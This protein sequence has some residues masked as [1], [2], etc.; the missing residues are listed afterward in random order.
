M[1]I[2]AVISSTDSKLFTIP[3]GRIMEIYGITYIDSSGA[4]NTIRVHDKG[5]YYD[6]T[7]FSST[8]DVDISEY[9]VA[10]N[11]ITNEQFK[12]AKEVQHELWGV[13]TG[14]GKVII[15]AKLI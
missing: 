7:D 1:I 15:N 12:E 11:G 5:N 3:D 13:G 14:T 4:A 6:G 2:E 8:F 10:A 9:P